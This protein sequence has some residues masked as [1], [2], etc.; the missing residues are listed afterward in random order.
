MTESHKTCLKYIAGIICF[1]TGVMIYL[2]WREGL[3][4]HRVI[5]WLGCNTLLDIL[6]QSVA[7]L[8]PPEWMIYSLPD[9]LWAL[10]YIL[11]ILAQEMPHKLIWA[12]VIPLVG[13]FSE[14]LQLAGLMPGTFDI[15]DLI[16][17]ILPLI[18]LYSYEFF[19][20]NIIY[21]H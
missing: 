11:I 12:S 15:I 8:Q 1:V 20:K 19:S 16:I 4:I 21:K 18:I 10:S 17:Y 5:S 6:N 3:L 7:D 13:F 9:G 14:L 2:L